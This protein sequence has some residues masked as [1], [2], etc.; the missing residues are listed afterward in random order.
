MKKTNRGEDFHTFN[1]KFRMRKIAFLILICIPFAGL[2]QKFNGGIIAGGLVSQVDG[3]TYDGY[4]KFGYLAGAYVS[5]HV[6][7]HNTWRI[8]SLTI[9]NDNI[10]YDSIRINANSSFQMEMEYIQKGSRKNSD[11][12]KGDTYSYLLRLHY[13]EIVLLYQYNFT[14]RFSLEAGPAADILL[15][16]Y[17]ESDGQEVIN[18]VPLRPVTLSGI[19][20]ISAYITSHLKGNFRFNYSLLSIRDATEPYPAGYR[21]ILF[22]WGQYNNVLSLSLLWD[23]KPKEL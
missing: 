5:L 18:T 11:L 19:I 4:H 22:E 1:E 14:K 8:D 16:S 21:K 7:K 17:E 15:G 13:L 10:V 23:F 2:A 20:G 12:E 9:L 3:D 6:F